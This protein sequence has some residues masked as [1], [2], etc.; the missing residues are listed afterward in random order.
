VVEKVK[1]PDF[2]DVESEL[3]KESVSAIEEFVRRHP[4]EVVSAFAFDADPGAGYFGV[5][6]DT[7]ENCLSRARDDEKNDL[8]RRALWWQKPDV[9]K[10]AMSVAWSTSIVDYNAY[11]GHFQYHLF[12]EVQFDWRA[13]LDSPDYDRLNRGGEDGWVEAQLRKVL[14][15]V[16]DRLVDANVFAKLTLASPFRLG[17]GY[18]GEPDLVVCRILNWPQ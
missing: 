18:P 9:W 13:F 5:C 7:R 6:F 14:S 3:V 10:R 8:E 4:G 11:V 1:P 12:H 2:E 17:Y 16:F 15:R